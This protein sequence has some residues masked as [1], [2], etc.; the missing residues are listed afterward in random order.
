MKKCRGDFLDFLRKIGYYSCIT[1]SF[2]EKYYHELLAENQ[3]INLFSRKMDLEE[4]WIRHFLDSISV[5]EV[6][7]DF[8]GKQ[9]LDFGTGGGIP[10]IPIKIIVPD[11][12]LT[13]LDSTKKKIDSVSGMVDR[14]GLDGVKYIWC[15]ME[16]PEMKQYYGGFDIIVSRGVKITLELSKVMLKLLK[17]DGKIILYKAME[18]GDTDRFK[19][20]E[21]HELK[22]EGLGVRKIVLIQN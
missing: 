6:F 21:V 14:L 7:Q 22:I 11:T 20:F 15:R 1:E 2:F 13:L 3:K 9:V 4:V 10:G 16:A 5:F 17:K 18:L 8:K 12:I 19:D